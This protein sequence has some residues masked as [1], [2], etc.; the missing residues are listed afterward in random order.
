[1]REVDKQYGRVFI[2]CD[3]DDEDSDDSFLEMEQK[4]ELFLGMVVV[5]YFDCSQDAFAQAAL[6]VETRSGPR[7]PASR[8]SHRLPPALRSTK[9]SWWCLAWSRPPASTS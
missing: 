3:S 5:K 9:T 4:Q 6:K 8:S 7:T 1:M 2:K